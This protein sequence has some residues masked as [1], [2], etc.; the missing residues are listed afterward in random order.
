M[1]TYI[2]KTILCSSILILVYYLFLEREKMYRFNRF[3]L[4]FGIAF[5]FL[6]PL[7]TI[8]TK[9]I[10]FPISESVKLA[11]SSLQSSL[12]QQI[13]PSI[14]DN[15]SLSNILFLIYVTVT[16]FLFFRFIV[17]ISV[18]FFK[19]KNNKSVKYLDTKLILTKDNLVPH[20]F[21]KY[22]F[23]YFKDF[24]NGT[25][26]KEIL[27]HEL[28]HVKQ[29]HS[30]D[31]LFI[32]LIMIFAWINPVLLLYRKAI[33]LN[34]EFLADEFVINSLSDTQTYQ[35]LLLDKARQTD[36][37][38]FS[39]PFNYLLIKRRIIMMTKNASKK[40]AIFKQ[41]ALIPVIAV[42]GFLFMTKIAAQDTV[43]K[44]QQQLA[45][46]TQ[47]GVSPEL[48]S[49]Y[50]NIINKYSQEI[51]NDSLTMVANKMSHTPKYLD[52]WT[53]LSKISSSDKER[54]ATI[55]FQMNK[56]QQEKQIVNFSEIKPKPK[57]IPAKE[58]FESFKDQD[59]YGISINYKQVKNEVLNNYTNTDF[60]YVGVSTASVKPEVYGK[61]I[62]RGF[63]MTNSY[64]Q[65]YNDMAIARKIFTMGVMYKDWGGY[66]GDQNLEK[67]ENK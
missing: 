19:I 11:S 7:I 35:L 42:I 8:K 45:V 2:L 15:F 44:S 14:N 40:V 17:N 52:R 63:L 51:K 6:V 32:E 22:V 27:G 46:F 58:Q 53:F 37:L 5:S 21:L 25:I 39:S 26:E 10:E 30:L 13:N 23:V 55:F 57:I 56:E 47:N 48:M 24:E 66:W 3:Y 38:V 60:S 50:K 9:I 18:I 41:I 4:L 54:L 65:S 62:Y 64:F 49:E 67:V 31:I 1:I 16:A 59:K 29:R 28:T 33:Q 36:S 20:S 34:H 61:P 12:P 43:K